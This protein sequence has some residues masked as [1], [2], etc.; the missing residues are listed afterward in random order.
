MKLRKKAEECAETGNEH[1][2]VI[3]FTARNQTGIPVVPNNA[4]AFYNVSRCTRVPVYSNEAYAAV[5]CSKSLEDAR[6][7]GNVAVTFSASEPGKATNK[8][9][10]IPNEAYAVRKTVVCE[11][12]GMRP[13]PSNISSK[14]AV[15]VYPNEAYGVYT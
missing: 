7:P 15:S 12:P 8:I 2:K 11:E 4:Y 3:H 14:V 13:K 1:L 5:K 10:I 6:K 9:P